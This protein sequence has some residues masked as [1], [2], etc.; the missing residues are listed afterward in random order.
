MTDKYSTVNLPRLS[1]GDEGELL[2]L[3]AVEPDA[4]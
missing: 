2:A 4:T 3:L 1:L